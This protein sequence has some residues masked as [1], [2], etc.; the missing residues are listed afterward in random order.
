[1]DPR[2]P[3]TP[4]CSDESESESETENHESMGNNKLLYIFIHTHFEIYKT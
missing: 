2:Y 3:F 4:E 1:M